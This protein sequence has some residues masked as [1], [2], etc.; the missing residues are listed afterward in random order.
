MPDNPQDKRHLRLVSNEELRQ[1]I[2]SRQ[3]S[4]IVSML[5]PLEMDIP[6]EVLDNLT[7]HSLDALRRDVQRPGLDSKTRLSIDTAIQQHIDFL[8]Y[9]QTQDADALHMALYPADL[10]GL[11]DLED[12][13]E[14]IGPDPDP[15]APPPPLPF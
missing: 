12:L 11:D 6:R 2:E 7:R 1:I 14:L 13:D 8:A 9:L 10:D 15:N 5:H 3:G 4:G